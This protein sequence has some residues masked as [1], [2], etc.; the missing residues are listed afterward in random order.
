MT[1][2]HAE[3]HTALMPHVRCVYALWRDAWWMFTQTL[4]HKHLSVLK[5]NQLK[6]AW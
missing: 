6:L 1:I 3:C 4:V 5:D 2:Q